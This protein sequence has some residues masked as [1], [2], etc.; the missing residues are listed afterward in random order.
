MN[1]TMQKSTA[2]EIFG[3]RA[4]KAATMRIRKKIMHERE[5]EEEEVKRM[6]RETAKTS[7][8]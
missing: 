7:A 4:A 3:K 5:E 8:I 1:M 2:A 6:V